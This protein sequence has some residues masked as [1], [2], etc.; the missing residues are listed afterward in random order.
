MTYRRKAVT[1]AVADR[2]SWTQPLSVGNLWQ[3]RVQTVDVVG[4]RAG[5]A[6]QQLAAVFTH[7]TELHV[8]VVFVVHPGGDP[9]TDL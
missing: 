5:V 1:K 8:V 4:G 2:A 9:H 3:R 6:A 7:P